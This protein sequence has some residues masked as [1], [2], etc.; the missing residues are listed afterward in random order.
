MKL[1]HHLLGGQKR[2]DQQAVTLNLTLVPKESAILP[3]V[4]LR[5]LACEA[6]G[7]DVKVELAISAMPK[8]ARDTLAG[9]EARAIVRRRGS[10]KYMPGGLPVMSTARNEFGALVDASCSWTPI[11]VQDE[12]VYPPK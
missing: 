1:C 2:K 4:A 7:E 12:G 11:L 3:V 9:L 10:W 8:H 6:M 5:E